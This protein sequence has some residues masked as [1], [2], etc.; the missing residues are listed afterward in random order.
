[1]EQRYLPPQLY[2][3]TAITIQLS[4][5]PFCLL[6]I[7]TVKVDRVHEVALFVENVGAVVRHGWTR[8]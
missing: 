4:G 5:A 1:L 6:I 8:N 7:R 3:I 2:A